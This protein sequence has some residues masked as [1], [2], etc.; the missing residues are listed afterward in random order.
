MRERAQA[1]TSY[2]SA[3]S[4]IACTSAI[5]VSERARAGIHLIVHLALGNKQAEIF[6]Y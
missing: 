3:L 2:M 6:Y 5:S 4:H 1:Y